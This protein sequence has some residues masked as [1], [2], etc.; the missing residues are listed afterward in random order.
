MII[1]LTLLDSY[2]IPGAS[3]Q[4]KH[5]VGQWQF[6]DPA[7]IRIGR[8]PDNDVVLT[9]P[10]E[11]SRYHLELRRQSPQR[12]VLINHGANGTF[13]NGMPVSQVALANNVVV[14]LAKG[15]PRFHIALQA[16]P[17]LQCTH[18]NNPPDTLFCIHCGEPRVDQEEFIR[19]YQVLRV[20]GQGGMGTTYLAWDKQ[21]TITGKPILLVLKEMNADL[22]QNAKAQE[23][24]EREARILQ[25]LTHDGIPRYYDFFV[26]RNKKYLAM[27]LV[28]GENL[29]QRIY[30]NGVVPPRV[31]IPWM[32][33]TCA[34]LQYLHDLNPPLVHRDVKPANL[35]LRQRD[36]RI[37]LLDFG[38]VKEIGTPLGT[39]IGAEG[40]SAPEQDRGQP[41]PQSDLFAI[42]PTLIFLLTGQSPLHFYQH[43]GH[44]YRLEVSHLPTLTPQLC[45]V[46]H[47]IA[48]PQ[49]KNR[50]QT[51]QDVVKALSTC[52]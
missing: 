47:K 3:P 37:V 39:R 52:L 29:E 46:V 25:S 41:C 23:L 1:T 35:M 33:Q 15:G 45:E 43:Q 32:I 36:Q 8:A 17:Q 5:P 20:L 30:Q 34:I 10:V 21:G 14:Q 49:L 7:R 51:A 6:R 48:E 12:W 50:Y 16:P 31:A 18:A 2:N 22:A 19:Q 9:D 13:L 42:A 27:E 11:V 40:Y 28:H 4:E 26:D 38:A 24:F 44:E